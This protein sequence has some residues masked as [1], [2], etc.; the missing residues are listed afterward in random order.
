MIKWLHGSRFRYIQCQKC[1]TNR[2]CDTVHWNLFCCI[3]TGRVCVVPFQFIVDKLSGNSSAKKLLYTFQF[4]SLVLRPSLW[5][6]YWQLHVVIPR[7]KHV[8]QRS[9]PA[10]NKSLSS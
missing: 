9:C 8:H 4:V 1:S 10:T 3:N 5:Y 2:F 6:F 7:E